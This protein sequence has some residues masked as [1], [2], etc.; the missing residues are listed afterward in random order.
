MDEAVVERSGPKGE[1]LRRAVAARAVTTTMSRLATS[2]SDGR[3]RVA[4]A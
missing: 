2:G 4:A 1:W 3:R